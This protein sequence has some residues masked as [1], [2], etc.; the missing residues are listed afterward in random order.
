MYGTFSSWILPRELFT[1]Q[2]QLDNVEAMPSKCRFRYCITD[3]EHVI[4]CLANDKI[5]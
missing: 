1:A 4:V 2:S 3:F 5:V